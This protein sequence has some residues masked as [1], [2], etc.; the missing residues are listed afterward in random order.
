MT[1]IPEF[2]IA[3]WLIEHLGRRTLLLWGAGGIFTCLFALG[4]VLIKE[5]PGLFLGWVALILITS[6]LGFY[7]VSYGPISWLYMSEVFPQHLRASGMS[8]ATMVNWATQAIVSFS[9]LATLNAFGPTFVF[10]SY[11]VI[12]VIAFAFIF[13]RVPETRGKTLEEL[14]EL[15]KHNPSAVSVSSAEPIEITSTSP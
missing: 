7:A 5:T 2:T 6:Y 12:G 1:R 10:W 4:L 13:Y 15:F 3:F 9:F 11:G 14:A 8:V